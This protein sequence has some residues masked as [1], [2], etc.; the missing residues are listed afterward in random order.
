[1]REDDSSSELSCQIEEAST[2]EESFMS[3]IDDN[4]TSMHSTPKSTATRSPASV[5]AMRS[6]ASSTAS[7]NGSSPFAREDSSWHCSF[8]VP[9]SKI[10][11]N[12]MKVLDAEKRPPATERR[13]IIRIV[14]A[15]ILTVCKKPDKRHKTEIARKMIIRYP[16]SFRDEIEGQVVGTGYDS[17]ISDR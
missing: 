7:E 9:W 3:D 16:K 11:T 4:I 10:P 8:E 2:G 5:I 17:D 13:E 6:Q 1:M 15:E 12:T 14:V